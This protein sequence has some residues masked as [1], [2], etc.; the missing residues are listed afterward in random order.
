MIELA[1]GSDIAYTHRKQKRDQGTSKRAVTVWQE[2]PC[3]KARH[4]C[5]RSVAI[6]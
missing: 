2:H 3:D 5:G 1:V 4:C 6:D